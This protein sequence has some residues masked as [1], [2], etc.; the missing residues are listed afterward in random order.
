[1]ARH[2]P[3][4]RARTTGGGDSRLMAYQIKQ[5]KIFQHPSIKR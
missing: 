4:R 1:M 5:L 3:G 2:R